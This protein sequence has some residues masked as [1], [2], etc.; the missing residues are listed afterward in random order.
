[1]DQFRIVNN[2]P[3]PKTIGRGGREMKYPFREMEVG[4]CFD[5]FDEK[6]MA[7]ARNAAY[8]EKQRTPEFNYGAVVYGPD[9]E[10]LERDEQGNI[11]AN[12]RYVYG[13]LWRVQA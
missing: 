10:E 11:I 6:A 13:R 4:Q 12:G 8:R 2:V 3:L 1:M 9:S 5:L 7:A